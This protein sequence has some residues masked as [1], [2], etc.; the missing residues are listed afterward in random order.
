MILSNW[1]ASL[2]AGFVAVQAAFAIDITVNDQGPFSPAS[3][4][5]RPA[6][7]KACL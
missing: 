4:H 3:K 5:S 1:M 6:D 7:P 2:L